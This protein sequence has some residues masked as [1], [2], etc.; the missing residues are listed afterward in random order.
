MVRISDIIR[1]GGREQPEE[2]PR[3][4]KEK[5]IEPEVSESKVSVELYSKIIAL[6]KEAIERIEK[7][8]EELEGSDV[9][10]VVEE[11]VG[12]LILK[13]VTLLKLAVQP[14]GIGFPYNHMVNVSILAVKIG[15][16]LAYSKV[17][18]VELGMAALFHFHDEKYISK[19]RILNKFTR[20]RKKE[21]VEKFKE[22]IKVTDIY[23]TLTHPRSY[24]REIDPYEVMKTTVEASK[25]FLDYEVVKILLEEISLYPLGCKVRLS[26]DE[27]GKVVGHNEH[28]PLRPKVE[29][30]LDLEGVNLKQPK[31][32]NLI[33]YPQIYIKAVVTEGKEQQQK[34]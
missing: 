18:L 19:I 1:G 32:I 15:M 22:I 21:D 3:P 12:Q 16:G 11:M 34:S 26:T 13:D 4:A 25:M 17:K 14:S 6:A 10:Q 31:L 27:I 30:A 24:R 29:V 9:K 23:E 28:F 33:K 2:K 5:K 20:E 8:G 7:K